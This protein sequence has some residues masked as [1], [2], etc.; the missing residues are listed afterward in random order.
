MKMSPLNGLAYRKNG[1]DRARLGAS[2]KPITPYGVRGA[3]S[4]G[5]SVER[6]KHATAFDPDGVTSDGFGHG[7]AGGLPGANVEPALVQRAFDLVAFEKAFAQSRMAMR[8]DVVGGEDL[9]ARVVQRDVATGDENAD[10][11]VCLHVI[12]GRGVDPLGL[13]SMGGLRSGK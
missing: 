6:E 11:L 7:S 8:A 10:H 3:P 12:H 2:A 13:L 1:H 4:G 5:G 9:A